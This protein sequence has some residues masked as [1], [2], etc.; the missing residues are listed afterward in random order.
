V[1]DESGGTSGASPAAA[2]TDV[3]LAPGSRE[4][5]PSGPVSDPAAGRGPLAAVLTWEDLQVEM[6]RLLEASA[7]GIGCD[8]RSR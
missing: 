6:G 5:T 4:V 1:Q 2:S 8:G 3:V 7:R